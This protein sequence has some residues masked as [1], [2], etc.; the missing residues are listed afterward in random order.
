MI[1]NQLVLLGSNHLIEL[2]R[3][4]LLA[5]VK[6]SKSKRLAFRKLKK[7]SCKLQLETFVVL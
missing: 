6:S 3:I 2:V 4:S 7:L 1:T 5:T